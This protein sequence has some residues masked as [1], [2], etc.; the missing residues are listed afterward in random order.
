[1]RIPAFLVCS[2]L[3][4]STVHADPLSAADREALLENPEKIRENADSRVDARFRLAIA[5]YREAMGSE[6]AAME[7]YLKCIEKVNFEDQQKKNADFRDW[8]RKE[9]DHLKDMG[10]RLA[11]RY[12]LRWLILTLRAS[13]EKANR[14]EL[15]VEAQEIVDSVFR[16]ADKLEDQGQALN[17]PVTATVFARAY[18]IGNLEKNEWPLSPV[19]LGDIYEKIIFPP[20]RMPTRVESLRAAW[21]KRIQQ[22]GIKIEIAGDNNNNGGGGGRRNGQPGPGPKSTVEH[23]RFVME[24]IP[25]FQWQM[26][27]DLFKSGDEAGAAMRMLAHIEKHLAH[28]SA[29]E[30]GQ[31]LKNLLTPKPATP[32]APA[33]T[34]P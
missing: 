1:M 24:R 33:G 18:E 9:D 30:W 4:V 7:F 13:S 25:E 3:T 31:Q 12:Q 32:V 16:D 8:K 19:D 26:E 34:Q 28:K 20:L 27:M 22:E 10:F 23:D 11:L 29:R 5:A 2:A 17:Q 14:S 15:A 21:I 6:E